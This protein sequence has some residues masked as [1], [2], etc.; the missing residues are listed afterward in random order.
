M[1]DRTDRLALQ[2]EGQMKLTLDK[3]FLA[4]CGRECSVGKLAR[5][6][7]CESAGGKST[8]CETWLAGLGKDPEWSA[9]MLKV[10]KEYA[11]AVDYL[12][13]GKSAPTFPKMFAPEDYDQ[14]LQQSFEKHKA[15]PELSSVAYLRRK[16][17]GLQKT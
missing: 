16:H 6:W 14:K 9:A 4:Q 3:W 13:R 17:F 15:Q 12:S 2:S 8:D 5:R 1:L 10:K 11:I 7:V